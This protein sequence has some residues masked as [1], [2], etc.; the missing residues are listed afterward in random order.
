MA[1]NLLG[2]ITLFVDL[3]ALATLSSA[4]FHGYFVARYCMP[5]FRGSIALR[6]VNQQ[7]PLYSEASI[8]V[9]E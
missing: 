6:S 2:L 5:L 8:L 4:V 3:M 1:A 9:K 7:P